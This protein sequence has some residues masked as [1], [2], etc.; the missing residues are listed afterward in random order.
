MNNLINRR[1]EIVSF[2]GLLSRINKIKKFDYKNKE[3]FEIRKIFDKEKVA[4]KKCEILKNEEKIELH[5]NISFSDDDYDMES[6]VSSDFESDI[7]SDFDDSESEDAPILLL[8]VSD[9]SVSST[10]QEILV[11]TDP[12]ITKD[13]W[14]FIQNWSIKFSI[15]RTAVTDLLHFLHKFFPNLPLDSLLKT[16][17]KI[18]TID[19]SPGKY[20]HVGLKK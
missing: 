19:I 4:K 11:N 6:D 13:V 9:E 1:S 5:G 14:T 18:H 12:A 16:P 8:N 2:K 20:Y 3:Q 17:R 15:Q 10:I 7:D